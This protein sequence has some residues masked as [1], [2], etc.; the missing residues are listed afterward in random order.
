M[1]NMTVIG[2]ATTDDE[3][4]QI[5]IAKTLQKM[6][7]KIRERILREVIFFIM[8]ACGTVTQLFFTRV[9][10][11]EDVKKTGSGFVVAIEQPVIMLNFSNMKKSKSYQMSAVAHEIA[12]YILGDYL[13]SPKKKKDKKAERHADDLIEKWGFKRVYKSYEKFEKNI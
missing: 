13:G 2:D 8:K 9:I 5:I 12:H 4:D 7:K 10:K 3:K 1:D 6:P 11:E